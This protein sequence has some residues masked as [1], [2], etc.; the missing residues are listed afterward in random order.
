[1]ASTNSAVGCTLRDFNLHNCRLRTATFGGAQF[2]GDASFHGARFTGDARFDRAQF[3]D[4]ASFHGA[5]FTGT[6]SF[7]RTRVRMDVAPDV[8]RVWPPGWGDG[9]GG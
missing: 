4:H 9:P 2:T 1:V 7:D 6:T 5:R 8:R 3:T